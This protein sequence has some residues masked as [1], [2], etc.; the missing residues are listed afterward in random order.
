MTMGT[1]QKVPLMRMGLM[2]LVLLF[3]LCT[4][5]AAVVTV[6]FL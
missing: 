5:F 6:V 1:V 4:I 3:A 2:V